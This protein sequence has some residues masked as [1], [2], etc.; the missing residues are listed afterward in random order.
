MLS[1]VFN[2]LH[3]LNTGKKQRTA[4]DAEVERKLG[5][6]FTAAAVCCYL[7]TAVC[8]VGSQQAVSFVVGKSLVANTYRLLHVL[9]M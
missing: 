4:A 1:R 2:A 3:S 7:T 9:L 5:V 6:R 8:V